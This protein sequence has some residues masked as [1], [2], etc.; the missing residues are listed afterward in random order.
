MTDAGHLDKVDPSELSEEEEE[1]PEFHIK[2]LAIVVS[3]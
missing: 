1:I 3:P 2:W